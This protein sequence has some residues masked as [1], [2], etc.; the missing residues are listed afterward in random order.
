MCG[1]LGMYG[2]TYFHGWVLVARSKVKNSHRNQL[3]FCCSMTKST[4][5]VESPCVKFVVLGDGKLKRSNVSNCSGMTYSSGSE[6]AHTF[7]CNPPVTSLANI[8][9]DDVIRL[10]FCII[11]QKIWPSRAQRKRA[12]L[13]ENDNFYHV[14]S[15]RAFHKMNNKRLI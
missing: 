4:M 13:M 5:A 11:R 14:K 9:G 7:S 10:C 6:T 12:F 15:F 1:L 2:G 3:V 8:M